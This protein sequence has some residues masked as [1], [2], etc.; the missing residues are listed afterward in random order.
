MLFAG[1]WGL[2]PLSWILFLGV[3]LAHEAGHRHS[4]RRAGLTIIGVDLQGL[5]GEVRWNG[6][7]TPREQ[8]LIAWSGVLA[9][10]GVLILA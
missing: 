6:V 4:V 10:L 2:S 1:G 3:V 9:Q 7:A 8:V 5:G